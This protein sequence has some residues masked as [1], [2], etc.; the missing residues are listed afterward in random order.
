MKSPVLELQHDAM[1]G[2]ADLT[3]LLRKCMVIATK[4]DLK[5][6][7]T[8]T[9]NE[10]RGY[11]DDEK[12]PSYRLVPAELKGFNPYNGMWL[13][14][15]FQE[16]EPTWARQRGLS[17]S[18]AELEAVIGK[19]VRHIELSLPENL[20]RHLME[21]AE[22]PRPPVS[23]ININCVIAVLDAVRNVI[24][25]WSLKL[26]ANGILGEGMV[27][28]SREKQAAMSNTYNIQNFNG[29][30]GPVNAAS[31]EIKN[32]TDLHQKLKDSG[33]SQEERN[34]I[35]SIMDEIPK[36]HGEA[37]KSLISRGSSWVLRNAKNLG[38][39]SEA[40]HSWIKGQ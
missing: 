2:D 16:D 8:W 1:N 25:D 31:V 3:S 39:L 28:T 13:P 24:L 23:H 18:I 20:A 21:S 10:L 33:I 19:S 35:E 29:I 30:L 12:L 38:E 37:K 9:N 4:L 26:E 27:F 15:M 6:F 36:S 11:T 40:I 32:Y 5:D 34:E 22:M 14:L 17:Q 7:L